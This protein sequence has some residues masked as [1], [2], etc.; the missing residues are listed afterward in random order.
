MPSNT[1]CIRVG[2]MP[3]D[4]RELDRRVRSVWGDIAD[5]TGLRT[6]HAKKIA[7]LYNVCRDVQQA[8]LSGARFETVRKVIELLYEVAIKSFG[9]RLERI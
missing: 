5:E 3:L 1:G 8:A 2:P 9:V 7:R 6:A 4:A